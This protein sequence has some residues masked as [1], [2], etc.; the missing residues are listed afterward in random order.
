MSESSPGSLRPEAD[1]GS[2]WSR[3][4]QT[5]IAV[6]AWAVILGSYFW[7]ARANDLTPFEAARSI[8]DLLRTPIWGAALYLLIY[9]L[10]PIIF[11]PATV[12][13]LLG[14]YVFGVVGGLLLTVIGSN[15]SAMV[16]YVIGRFLGRD[17]LEG[18]QAQKVLSRYTDRLRENSF[19]SV[20]IMRFLFL[21]Y[22]LVNYLCGFLRIDPK[23]FLLATALGSI[24]GTISFV[25]A[26]ASVTGELGTSGA[27]L[28]PRAL[29]ASV[30]IFILSIAISR[31]V[32]RR[33]RTETDVDRKGHSE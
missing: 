7:Y 26:G 17:V 2:F 20:L 21:P 32:K 3:H 18:E 30:I 6:L 31:V 4:G 28:D 15:T 29:I 10:R 24:P 16:A 23:A 12:L 11:F 27:S 33:E 1:S 8:D 13:T 5:V 25:L 19:E 22:D 14:G 9:A